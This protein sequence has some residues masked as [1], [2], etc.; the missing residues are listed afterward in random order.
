MRIKMSGFTLIELVAVLVIIGVLAIAAISRFFDTQVFD[1]RGFNDQTLATLRFAQKTAIAQRRTVCVTF[2]GTTVTLIMATAAG[3][4]I[5]CIPTTN[6][7][8]PTG[9]TPYVLTAHG[10]ASFSAIPANFQFNSLGQ[11]IIA[12]QT[13]VMQV[14]GASGSITIE[15][16]TGY[17]HP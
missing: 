6:L 14:I 7:T 9:V 16:A 17:V 4:S 15:G 11:A 12:G 13:Q 2:T 8:S 5:T 10:S 1:S 3:A